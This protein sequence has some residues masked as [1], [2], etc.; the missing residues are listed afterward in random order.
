MK[1]IILITS[2]R[3]GSDFFQS[4]LDGHDQILSLPGVFYF[5]EFLK[6]KTDF[7]LKFTKIYE[8]FFDSRLNTYERHHQLGLNKNEF[9]RVSKEDFINHYN[10]LTHLDEKVTEKLLERIHFAYAKAKGEDISKKKLLFLH[11]HH[12]Y[13]IK[14]THLKNFDIFYTFRDPLAN[15]SSAFK[16]WNKYKNG[17]FFSFNELKNYYIRIVNGLNFLEKFKKNIYIVKLEN[18]HL[19]SRKLIKNFCQIY[20]IDENP[21][22]YMATFFNKKWWG[23]EVSEKYLDGINNNF[24]NNIDLSYFFQRDIYYIEFLMNN[25]MTTLNYKT[26]S[27]KNYLSFFFIFPTKMELLLLKKKIFEGKIFAI[28]GFIINWIGRVNNL[29][30]KKKIYKPVK[31]L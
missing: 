10:D 24:K 22:L 15:L 17:I 28:F 26:T 3:T 5:D 23:D 21:S 27:K 1:K 20:N 11:L 14:Q 6:V 19:Q 2:G 9:Y 13:R 7:A 30:F 16:N 29:G 4:L 8:K 31:I 25:L 18:L 12:I